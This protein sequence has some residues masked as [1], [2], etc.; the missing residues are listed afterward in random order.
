M[1]TIRT[2][3]ARAHGYARG[4]C[5]GLVCA[6]V[7]AGAVVC[8][9][10]TP[11]LKLDNAPLTCDTRPSF[12]F[13]PVYEKVSPSVVNIY[14][15]KAVRENPNIPPFFEDPF[16]RQFFGGEEVKGERA[17]LR[18]WSGGGSHYLVVE[19]TPTKR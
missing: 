11:K 12:T 17:L 4:F 2:S 9:A 18:V 15:T 3:F 19:A 6:Q 5:L 10:T 7:L 14:S 8:A 1:K 16:F 13:R